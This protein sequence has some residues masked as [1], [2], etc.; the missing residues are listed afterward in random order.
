MSAPRVLHEPQGF[1]GI[2]FCGQC[3]SCKRLQHRRKPT[4]AEDSTHGKGH[5]AFV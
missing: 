3:A 4:D 1:D 5:F 2:V